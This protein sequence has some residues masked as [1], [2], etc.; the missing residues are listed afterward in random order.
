MLVMMLG[1]IAIVAARMVV[2]VVVAVIV[3]MIVPA[4]RRARVGMA[5]GKPMVAGNGFS[6]EPFLRIG[7]RQGWLM[8]TKPDQPAGADVTFDDTDH[9][10]GTVERAHARF[11]P[12]DVCGADPV[13][14]G[15]N[16]PVGDGDLLGRLEL[17]VQ[18]L[19]AVLG[20]DGRHHAVELVDAINAFVGHQRMHD[21]R[22]IG[23]AGGLKH[24]AT[25]RRDLAPHRLLVQLGQR[26]HQIT[27]DGAADATRR[28]QNSVFVSLLDQRVIEANLAEFVDDHRRA[29]HAGIVQQPLQQRCLAGAKIA[30]QHGHGDGG[31]HDQPCLHEGIA[32]DVPDTILFEAK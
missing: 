19:Q 26:L 13:C 1:V 5:G 30:G 11:E 3:V 12:S 4:V 25:D 27:A 20:I 31:G 16:D 2:R 6:G 23:E 29:G 22:R 15:E 24:H 32:P 18:L 7:A 17:L 28:E 8:G 21:R 14:L 10:A 9:L